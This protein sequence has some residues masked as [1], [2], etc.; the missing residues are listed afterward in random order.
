MHQPGRAFNERGDVGVLGAGHEIP[1]PMA[2][3]GSILHLSRALGDGDGIDDLS[4][5]LP[6]L[7]GALAPAHRTPR[8]QMRG[9]LALQ[10]A[11]CL[12][13]EAPVDRLMRHVERGI[14]RV[15]HHQPAGNLRR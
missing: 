13:E 8:P 11:A 5:R 12:H 1:L 10:D 4:P 6:G 15:R 14:V 2:R 9:E 7:A 3:N